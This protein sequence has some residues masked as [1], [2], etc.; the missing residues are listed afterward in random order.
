MP[1]QYRPYLPEDFEALNAL[2]ELCFEPPFRFDR[3]YMRQLVHRPHAAVWIAEEEGRMAGFA[4]VDWSR[5]KDET[6]AY[7]QTI[8]VDPELRGRGVGN[9]LMT[10]V[11][12]SAQEAGAAQIR[13]HVE[14]K[15]AA[16]IRLYEARGYVCEGRRERFYPR[17]R[18]ALIYTKRLDSGT[19]AGGSPQTEEAAKAG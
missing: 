16:A 19:P 1:V 11:E 6:T 10:R 17:G 5:R 3:H 7:I 15:N 4:I 13:L 9:E 8:E 14:S 2:E 18:A 12:T